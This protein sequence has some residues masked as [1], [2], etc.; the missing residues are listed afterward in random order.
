MIEAEYSVLQR[1][2]AGLEDFVTLQRAHHQFLSTLRAKFYLD[3]LEISQVC[4]NT[5]WFRREARAML[6]YMSLKIWR[7]VSRCSCT[8]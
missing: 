3:N 1:T 6:M 8:S 4:A 2:L 7:S 5:N